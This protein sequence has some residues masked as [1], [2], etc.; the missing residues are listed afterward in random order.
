MGPHYHHRR[1]SRPQASKATPARAADATAPVV[2]RMP[3]R[4]APSVV[5]A[6]PFCVK[7]ATWARLSRLP[8][9]TIKRGSMMS[10]PKGKIPYAEHGDAIIGDSGLII[11]YLTRTY[12]ADAA[13]GKAVTGGAAG[14][15]AFIPFTALT[16]AQQAVSV[17]VSRT[18]EEHA[19]QYLVYI[20]WVKAEVSAPR[21]RS[22]GGGL[23]AGAVPSGSRVD[24]GDGGDAGGGDGSVGTVRSGRS[25]AW[26]TLAPLSMAPRKQA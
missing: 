12:F 13:A 2:L 5:S 8:N 24:A 25:T 16:P 26:T 7:L 1:Y 11:D 14:L 22:G 18:I 9:I 6:S 20:N 23:V 10:S 17:A 21:H 3:G 4:L 19:Y 15:P